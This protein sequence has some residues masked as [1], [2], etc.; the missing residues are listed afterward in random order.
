MLLEA[1]RQFEVGADGKIRPKG[2]KID[3]SKITADELR[4]LGIDPNLSQKEIAKKLKVCAATDMF[5]GLFSIHFFTNSK[6]THMIFK[7]TIH[8]V[9]EGELVDWRLNG[10]VN[11]LIH[12]M[13]D[14]GSKY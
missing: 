3:L 10:I 7:R 4:A 11:V 5:I 1:E 13:V 8:K 9:L 2:K 12:R 14:I 6:R